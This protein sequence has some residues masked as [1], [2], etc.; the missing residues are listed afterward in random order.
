MTNVTMSG[1]RASCPE[2]LAADQEALLRI[3][4]K[5]DVDLVVLGAQL[6]G[7]R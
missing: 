4:V 7:C 5:H 2:S 1:A 6:R 3:L